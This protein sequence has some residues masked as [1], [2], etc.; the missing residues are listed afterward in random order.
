MNT[1]NEIETEVAVRYGKEFISN[2][3]EA[4]INAYK[5]FATLSNEEK[6]RIVSR[7]VGFD[8]F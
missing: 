7:R 8:V 3:F 1:Y 2:D 5:V 4:V 6:N